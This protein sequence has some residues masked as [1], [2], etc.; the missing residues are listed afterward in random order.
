LRTG[1]AVAVGP[2]R[3]RGYRGAAADAASGRLIADEFAAMLTQPPL[4]SRMLDRV[5]AMLIDTSVL[6]LGLAVLALLYLANEAGFLIGLWRS[7][8]R[9]AHE[10]DLA[11]ISTITAG[12]LGL[13]A[14]TLGL[15]I[16]IA[17]SRFETRRNLV[18]Q[19]ANAISTA[20]QR[21]KLIV[22]DEGPPITALLE[23][24]A[25]VELAYVSADSFDVEPQLIARG[26][27]LETQILQAARTVA[28]R[29]PSWMTA[30][31]ITALLDM[32]NVALS[33][34][35]A[36]DSRV[37]T[38]LSWM[39]MGGSLL[40]IGAMGYHLGASG[41]RQI[42]LTSLLLVMWAGGMVLIADLNRPRVGVIRVDPSPLRWTIEGFARP[43]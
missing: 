17:Q 36:F 24:F 12:M 43:L 23:D 33:E 29:D 40:A 3:F 7:R 2:A 25:K 38:D 19:E 22:G 26:N 42:V 39:L 20:W 31:L 5:F 27:E 21:S 13:L 32:F 35:F 1:R 6:L 41:S 14:F 28:R 34:R 8:H 30:S 15:T 18:V 4:E 11:G 37:P 9:P 16:N 10:R